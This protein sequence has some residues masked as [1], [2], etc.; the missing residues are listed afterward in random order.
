MFEGIGYLQVEAVIYYHEKRTKTTFTRG[1]CREKMEKRMIIYDKLQMKLSNI[2]LDYDRYTTA[3]NGM[4][5][6]HF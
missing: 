6:A 3:L 1:L 2:R 5:V 4:V